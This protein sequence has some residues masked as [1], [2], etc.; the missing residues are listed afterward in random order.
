MATPASA[1]GPTIK[2]Q[3]AT[4]LGL[5]LVDK[6]VLD[7]P[8]LAADPYGNFIPGPNGL[9][10]YV[11]GNGP[12]RG[13]PRPRRW[14]AP[15]DARHFDTPFLTDIAHNADPRRRTPTTTPARRTVA[16]TPDADNTARP[17]SPASRRARTTTRCWTRTSSLW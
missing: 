3:A 12:G 11:T 4:K 9:P 7:I 2:E 6:D 15:A 17:T 1:P 13:Q 5:Q 16:P 8:M 14:P 10:Q